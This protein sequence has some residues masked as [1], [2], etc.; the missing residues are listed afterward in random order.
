MVNKFEIPQEYSSQLRVVEPRDRRTNDEIIKTLMD[1]KP[2]TSE[3]NLWAFWDKG[4]ES[5]PEWCQRNVASWVRLLGPSWSVRVLDVV[6]RSPNHA[7]RWIDSSL[8]PEAFVKGTMDG[9]WTGPHSADLLRGAALFTYGG[10]WMDVGCILVRPFDRIFWKQ[11]ED[12]STPYLVAAPWLF[13]C[14]MANHFVAARK[15][16]PFI[17]AWH[18]LFVHFWRGRTNNEGIGHEP[19]IKFCETM[20]FDGY[21][22]AGFIWDMKVDGFTLNQYAS[23]VL[24]WWRLCIINGGEKEGEFDYADYAEKHIL[25]IEGFKEMYGAQVVVG[26]E[27]KDLWD[28]FNTRLDADPK[29]EEYQRAHKMVWGM[30]TKCCWQKVSHAKELTTYPDLGMLWSMKPGTDNAPGTFTELLRYGAEH[31]EQVREEVLIKDYKKPTTVM[32]KGLYEP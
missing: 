17:K 27:G 30:L 19:L 25:W 32:T 7:L 1:P 13:D 14:M 10:A 6:P 5:M 22:S 9:P 3:K 23:Q 4:V 26:M 8:L 18:D 21:A 28:A 20:G 2:V 31:F 24:A 11:L 15:G 12:P 29:S 16:N